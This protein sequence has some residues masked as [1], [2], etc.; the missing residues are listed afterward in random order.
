MLQ[1]SLC[2][3]LGTALDIN[4]EKQ[5]KIASVANEVVLVLNVLI[6][7]VN[8][9]INAFDMKESTDAAEKMAKLPM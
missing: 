8:V 5:Q 2:V 7:A 3:V 4:K 6:V 9:I 1:A